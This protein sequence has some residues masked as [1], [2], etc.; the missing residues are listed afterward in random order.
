MKY[1]RSLLSQFGRKHCIGL[2]TGKHADS[3]LIVTMCREELE[4]LDPGFDSD[5]DHVLRL[6]DFEDV[7]DTNK[8]GRI[9]NRGMQ[10]NKVDKMNAKKAT[11]KGALF[12]SGHP[13]V[14]NPLKRDCV[15][16]FERG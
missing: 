16:F 13:N 2:W 15:H 8:G 14:P 9:G 7:D 3:A 11:H 4:K 1:C 10:K 6:S 12:F 5:E